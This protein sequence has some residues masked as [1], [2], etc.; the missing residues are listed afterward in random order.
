MPV[1]VYQEILEDG[2]DGELLEIEQSMS[3]KP[4]ERHPLTGRPVRRVYLPPTVTTQ[5]TAGRTKKLLT[6]Q[7]VAKAGFTKYVRDKQT[8]EYH[9]TAGTDP[10][11]PDVLR[12]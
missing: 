4:L 9:K 8:G 12:K 3:A 2:S 6:E 5:Y 1:Y 7:N 11:A 10:R